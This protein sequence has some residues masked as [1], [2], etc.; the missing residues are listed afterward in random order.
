MKEIIILSGY[1]I[2][3]YFLTKIILS[4]LAKMRDRELRDT[5]ISVD[6]NTV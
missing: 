2:Y 1:I 6:K 4:S 5:V 3:L